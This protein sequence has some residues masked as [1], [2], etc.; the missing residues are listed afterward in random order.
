M[1]L[2]YYS[3]G[4]GIEDR[5]KK[6]LKEFYKE[7]FEAKWARYKWYSKIKGYHVL[8]AEIDGELV[9]Q[10]C[11]CPCQLSIGGEVRTIYWS[12]DSFV[13][14][15]CRGK[16]VGKA[17]QKK[18]HED[19]E[20]FSS[21]SYSSVNGHIKIKCGAHPISTTNFYY[22]PISSFVSLYFSFAVN[23]LFN[24]HLGIIRFRNLYV[25]SNYS[26]D[27]IIKEE[28]G[29]NS[30]DVEFANHTLSSRYD[31]YVYRDDMYMKWKYNE[32][33]SVSYI[34]LKVVTK[35]NIVGIVS[36]S[37][38]SIEVFAGIPLSVVKILDFFNPLNS[39]LSDKELLNNIKTWIA[40]NY[41]DVDVIMGVTDIA[42]LLK[43]KYH[44]RRFLTN[45]KNIPPVQKPYIS[46]MDQDVE[47][48]Q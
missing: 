19:H 43:I 38:P 26:K 21:T 47:Q 11:A 13:L 18:L 6:F 40:K 7:R 5:Y 22:Y 24:K 12:V 2:F 28:S 17:L 46:C 25:K 16:G 4:L 37:K 36:V 29:W 15:I 48:M 9:G 41:Q 27:I 1:E 33:P 35:E 3:E 14:T 10:S 23:K 44:T 30:K 32:N 39:G 45:L 42:T 34:I 8:L 20:G 31:M